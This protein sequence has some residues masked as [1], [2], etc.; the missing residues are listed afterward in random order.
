[1]NDL[2]SRQAAL[3]V[4]AK[5]CDHVRPY[6]DAWEM[7]KN[8]PAADVVEVKCG[9]WVAADIENTDGT[10]S[11]YSKCSACDNIWIIATDYCPNCGADMR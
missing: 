7:L 2:I 6:M 9:K 4:M 5:C 3:G 1:M 11:F 8:L 10:H